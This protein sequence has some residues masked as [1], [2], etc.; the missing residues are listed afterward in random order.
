MDYCIYHWTEKDVEIR[1]KLVFCS[2]AL[3]SAGWVRMTILSLGTVH[4]QLSNAAVIESQQ[5]IFPIK[6]VWSQE[7]NP[8]WW[9][10]K[11]KRYLCTMPTP[12]ELALMCWDTNVGKTSF[13]LL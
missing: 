7:S 9:G 8:G 3:T 13:S 10:E 6:N 5:E 2:T 1:K 12:F 11:R 4:Q